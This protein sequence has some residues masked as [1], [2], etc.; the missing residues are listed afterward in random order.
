VAGAALLA[1]AC[2]PTPEGPGGATD[3]AD[4]AAAADTSSVPDAPPDLPTP[5]DVGGDARAPDVW[6]G[7][8]RCPADMALVEADPLVVCVDRYEASRPDA[9]WYAAGSDERHATSRREVLPW[10][11]GADRGAAA[12]ACAAAGKR[13]CTGPEWQQACAG[14]EGR[15]Y[16]YGDR[17]REDACNGFEANGPGAFQLL[18]TGRMPDCESPW[19]V[20][21]LSGNVWELV[22]AGADLVPRGGAYDST[23]GTS[24]HRCAFVRAG[25]RT[26]ALGFRCCAEPTPLRR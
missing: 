21:D 10:L 26:D 5:T 17:Y 14:P 20:F 8:W 19:G 22:Q 6:R 13:L 16:P 1:A 12:A 4:V 24:T 18:P 15:A 23:D 3:A 2:E 11:L 9:T 7:P 25:G